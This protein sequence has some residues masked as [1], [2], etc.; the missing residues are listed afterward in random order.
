MSCGR[1]FGFIGFKFQSLG[2]ISNISTS[3]PQFFP[4]LVW[5]ERLS[6]S[7][8]SLGL[9]GREVTPELTTDVR[10]RFQQQVSSEVDSSAPA[11]SLLSNNNNNITYIKRPVDPPVC[12]QRDR[13]DKKPS[14]R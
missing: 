1:L 12:G 3:D 5:N 11:V 13:D 6:A 8:T 4:T 10:I 9:H 2:K 7:T 14:C